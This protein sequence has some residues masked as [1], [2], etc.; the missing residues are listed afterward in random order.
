LDEHER[1]DAVINLA[2]APILGFP[3]TR[4]R[5]RKLIDSRVTTT[6]SLV[7][8]CGR[9]VHA[10]RIFITASAIGYYGL[11]GDEP[12]DETHPPQPLFQSRL[13]QEWEATADAVSGVVV[14]VVKMRIGLVLGRDGGALPQLAL[15]V[16]LGLGAVLGS[17]KQW[18]TWIHIDDLVRLFEF[19]LDTPLLRGPL[20]AVSPIAAQHAQVQSAIAK[21]LHRPVWM[22]IPAWMIRT[23]MGEMSQLLVDGQRAVPTRATAAGFDFKYPNIGAAVRHLLGRQNP[24]ATTATEIYYSGEW[25][26]SLSRLN[27]RKRRLNPFRA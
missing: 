9:L 20:N 15:P 12:L 4:A 16:R 3:W 5:R 6:R 26:R 1:I 21:V 27:V 19:V 18:V 11:G 14:R 17:G 13:C 8:L 7:D 2:G 10:P 24:A 25:A 23:L 22:R